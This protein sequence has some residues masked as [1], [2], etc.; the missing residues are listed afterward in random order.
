MRRRRVMV[1]TLVVLAASTQVAS[2]CDSAGEGRKTAAQ[3]EAT[4]Q[5][6]CGTAS[7]ERR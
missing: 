2:S 5:R 7:E 4:I 6:V 1:L 3:I